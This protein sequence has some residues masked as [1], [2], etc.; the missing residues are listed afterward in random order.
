MKSDRS[1]ALLAKNTKLRRPTSAPNLSPGARVSKSI[2]RSPQQCSETNWNVRQVSGI[3]LYLIPRLSN[4]RLLV[5][6]CQSTLR[7][8]LGAQLWV[9]KGLR[10]GNALGLHLP[11]PLVAQ[12]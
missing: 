6:C 9:P 5:L 12:T 3:I 1:I 2:H 8:V 7:I 10:S 11:T 4:L